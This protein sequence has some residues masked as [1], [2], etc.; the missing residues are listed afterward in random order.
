MEEILR[1]KVQLYGWGPVGAGQTGKSAEEIHEKDGAFLRAS[2]EKKGK[3][4]ERELKKGW[5]SLRG[6]SKGEICLQ[7]S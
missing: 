5:A 2:Q 4:A 3:V 1:G 7:V 6:K